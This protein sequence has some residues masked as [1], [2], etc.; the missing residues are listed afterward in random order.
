VTQIHSTTKFPHGTG[1]LPRE[2]RS[3]A[4]WPALRPHD[5]PR[6]PNRRERKPRRPTL[7]RVAKQASKAGIDVVRYEVK[8]DSINIITAKGEPAEPENPWLVELRRKE[9]R[10]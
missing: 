1:W 2:F 4:L 10:R 3:D 9:T 5:G 7:A 8:S 6:T